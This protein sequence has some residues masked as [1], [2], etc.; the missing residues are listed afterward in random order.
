MIRELEIQTTGDQLVFQDAK[1]AARLDTTG[2][3]NMEVVEAT[4]TAIGF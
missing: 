3:I 4:S 1:D 2:S